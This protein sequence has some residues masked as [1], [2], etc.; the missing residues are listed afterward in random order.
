MPLRA[1]HEVVPLA[2]TNRDESWKRSRVE[3]EVG[4]DVSDPAASGL[5]S[6]G[7]DRVALAEVSV[8]VEDLHARQ[9]ALEHPF[10]CSVDGAVRDDDDLE[11]ARPCPAAIALPDQTDV[12]DDRIRLVVDRNDDRERDRD[13]ALHGGHFAAQ[14]A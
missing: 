4:I 12:P 1:D 2:L 5:A 8:V 9:L 7:L 3:V 14:L 10:G 11:R 13:F 6:T